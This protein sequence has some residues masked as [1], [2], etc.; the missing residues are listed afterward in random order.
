[1]ASESVP[2]SAAVKP[3][4]RGHFH[5]SAFFF[6]F[7]ACLMLIAD[8]PDVEKTWAACIY[9]L[10][11]VTMLGVSALYHRGNWNEKSRMMLRRLDHS[12]IFI[13]I[14]GT[15]TPIAMISLGI[16][17]GSRLLATLWLA[18]AIGVIQSLF[19]VK[20]PK[21]VSAILYIFVGWLSVPYLS[22]MKATL[23]LQGVTLLLAGGVVYTLGAVVY[24]MKKPNPNPQVF[25]YHEIFHLLVVLAAFL[26][27][28]VIVKIVN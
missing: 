27:F 14:A 15:A 21:W 20:A 11:L 12:A 19:W 9:S 23:G 7:G 24:A 3:L 13:L 10:S 1:V 2:A 6:A 8:A 28:L 18:A 25:G 22:Q 16:E 5:Q 4:L 17:S 26:H